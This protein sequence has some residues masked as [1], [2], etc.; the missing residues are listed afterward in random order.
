MVATSLAL[1]SFGSQ[2]VAEGCR[3]LNSEQLTFELL[4]RSTERSTELTP[5]S[6][7]EVLRPVTGLANFNHLLS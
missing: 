4:Q 3:S 2:W 5:K 1:D 7:A 6:H